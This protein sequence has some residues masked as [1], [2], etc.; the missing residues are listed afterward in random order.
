M[1]GEVVYKVMI[2]EQEI[3]KV[4]R[5]GGGRLCFFSAKGFNYLCTYLCMCGIIDYTL[6]SSILV[7]NVPLKI[8]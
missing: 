3:V 4:G 5:L 7:G 1:G 8:P 6:L 2:L